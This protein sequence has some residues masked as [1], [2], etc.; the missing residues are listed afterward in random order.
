L[1]GLVTVD[2]MRT[3]AEIEAAVELKPILPT[4]AGLCSA[5]GGLI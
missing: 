3:L 5:T 2:H 4:P 1:Q